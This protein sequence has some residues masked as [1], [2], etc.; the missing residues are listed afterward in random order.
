MGWGSDGG[1]F[2]GGGGGVQRGD[3]MEGGG[4]QWGGGYNGGD[5]MWGG[6]RWGVYNRGGLCSVT[7][8]QACWKECIEAAAPR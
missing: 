8:I 7:G 4:I 3:P 2:N 5:L 6:V 1:G